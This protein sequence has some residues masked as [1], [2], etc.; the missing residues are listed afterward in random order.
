MQLI[1]LVFNSA[2]VGQTDS[3]SLPGKGRLLIRDCLPSALL[4]LDYRIGGL[5]C[6]AFSYTKWL[7][8]NLKVLFINF[9]V[10]TAELRMSLD[11]LPS[12]F[13][14]SHPRIAFVALSRIDIPA[15]SRGAD[16]DILN[17][18]LL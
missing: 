1:V 4:I 7:P 2:R 13:C 18:Q 9:L 8:F 15:A 14:C 12:G 11:V 5:F 17:I 6:T 10:K 16:T 3:E